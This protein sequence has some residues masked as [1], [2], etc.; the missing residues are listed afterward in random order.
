MQISRPR[1]SKHYTLRRKVDFTIGK[2]GWNWLH[3]SHKRDL[4]DNTPRDS[5]EGY[6]WHSDRTDIVV[7][8]SRVEAEAM[9]MRFKAI[10]G[11]KHFYE[12]E[13]IA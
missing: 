4:R 11:R 6:T 10:E 7:F 12:V 3:P 1:T 2:H 13:E 8:N 5:I 9:A